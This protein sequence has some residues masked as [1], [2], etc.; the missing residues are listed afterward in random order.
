MAK[1]SNVTSPAAPASAKPA[2][3]ASGA[4]R[5]AD[6]GATKSNGP[7]REVKPS[8]E[9]IRRRAY[10][11]YQDRLARGIRGDANTDWLQAEREISQAR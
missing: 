6:Q 10:E 9:L 7:V 1:R 4:A 11:I 3:Q 5:T 2:P 8:A